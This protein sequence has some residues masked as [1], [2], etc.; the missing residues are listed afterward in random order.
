MKLASHFYLRFDALSHVSRRIH[1]C[2][3]SAPQLRLRDEYCR[4]FYLVS[5]LERRG[6][7]HE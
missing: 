5:V 7:N 4:P 3:N 1:D 6:T 2:F